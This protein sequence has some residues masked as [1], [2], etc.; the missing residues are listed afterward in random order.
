MRR[1]DF[2]KTGA[3][4]AVVGAAVSA[5]G[6]ASLAA[7][8]LPRATDAPPIMKSYTAADHRRRLE[9]IGL[10]HRSIRT[11][12]RKHL[13]TE[14][15]PGQCAYNLG[16]YPCRTPWDPD[17]Y[18]EQELDKLRDHGI[19]LIQVFDEWNDSLRLCGRHKLTALNPDGF[20]GLEFD[21][22]RRLHGIGWQRP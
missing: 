6:R 1:R 18:D 7:E 16:E 13:V 5:S 14:Y 9:N 3:S 11:C 19:Q 20:Q 22:I 17:E 2:L 4:A 10:C 21:R 8:S 12:L 15:L